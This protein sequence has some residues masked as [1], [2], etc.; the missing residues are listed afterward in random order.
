MKLRIALLVVLVAATWFTAYVSGKRAAD[1]WY[2]QH[3]PVESHI[4][5]GVVDEGS[6]VIWVAPAED[7]KCTSVGVPGHVEFKR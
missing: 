6:T 5:N 4:Y 3:W 2:W 7:I 1:R